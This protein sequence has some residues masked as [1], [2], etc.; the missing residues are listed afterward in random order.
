M[1]LNFRPNFEKI[2]ELL[3]YLAHRKPGADKYQAVKFFYLADK[4]HLNR[5]GRPITFEAYFALPYGPV[6]SKA[7]ELLEGDKWTLRDAGLAQL[8][9]TTER[10][11]RAGKEDLIKIVAPQRPVDFEIFSKS[12]IDVFDEILE[13]YGACTFDE[14]FHIT[15]DHAAYKKA[16]ESRPKG[17]KAAPMD[18][19]DMI[20]SPELRKT[21]AEDIGPIAA[22]L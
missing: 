19:I 9:L 18:Y 3:V 2:V 10:I 17:Y 16:W 13:K 7:K 1:P 22:H 12:D 5:F 15:H 14:L 8:P 4:E 11:P 21:V 20:D 6:A